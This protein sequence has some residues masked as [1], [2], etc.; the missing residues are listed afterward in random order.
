MSTPSTL[1]LP[2][3][4]HRVEADNTLTLEMIACS[5]RV[6]LTNLL[7]VHLGG[8]QPELVLVAVTPPA[9]A[10]HM[11]FTCPLGRRWWPRCRCNTVHCSRVVG[12][13]SGVQGSEGL[14][15][16]VHKGVRIRRFH[17]GHSNRSLRQE[18]QGTQYRSC[19]SQAE[20][21][22]VCW[23]VCFPLVRIRSW[24]EVSRD[25]ILAA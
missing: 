22:A 9:L 10:L 5:F 20:L 11:F 18:Q 1:P 12:L 15:Q 19:K 13:L 24:C 4:Q 2:A 25:S 3:E 21:W 23:A 14:C 8:G 17:C 16:R 7:D 6:L